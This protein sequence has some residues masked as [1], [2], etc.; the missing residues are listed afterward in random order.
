MG[1]KNNKINKQKYIEQLKIISNKILIIMKRIFPTLTNNFSYKI[2]IFL[3]IKIQKISK[4]K[5]LNP[6]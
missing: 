1:K 6:L 3:M 5:L 2:Q 4:F